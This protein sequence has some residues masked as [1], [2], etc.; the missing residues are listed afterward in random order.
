MK[1]KQ[2]KKIILA[3][4]VLLFLGCSIQR[5]IERAPHGIRLLS[6][7]KIEQAKPQRKAIEDERFLVKK[8]HKTL[9]L[10][11]KA[12]GE[13]D[14][15]IR[16]EAVEVLGKFRSVAERAGHV[17]IAYKVVIPKE[18]LRKSRKLE[19][20]PEVHFDGKSLSCG[21]IEIRGTL[22]DMLQKRQ[23]WQWE[24]WK[25]RFHPTNNR[26]NPERF[27]ALKK[28]PAARIDSL[29][30]GLR[31][32]S[33]YLTERIRLESST[34]KILSTIRCKAQNTNL[35]S[36]S[37]WVPDTLHFS[38][39]SM[40]SFVDNST[41]Y[42]KRIRLK[43]KLREDVR[44]IVFPVGS[45]TI[46]DTLENNQEE[47]SKILYLTDTLLRGINYALDSCTV[48]AY[49]SPEGSIESNMR[50]SQMRAQSVVKRLRERFG[51]DADTIFRARSAGENW[52]EFISHLHKMPCAFSRE[53]IKE[54]SLNENRDLILRRAA[55]RYP[56]QYAKIQQK[57]FPRLR[58]VRFQFFLHDRLLLRDTVITTEV[59][60]LYMRG[61]ELLKKRE[62]KQALEILKD[63]PGINAA[64]AHMSLSHDKTALEI[65]KKEPL[66]AQREYL[67]SILFVRE[68]MWEQAKEAFFI[69]CRLDENMEFRSDMDP[70]MSE[71]KKRIKNEKSD[72]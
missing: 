28:N 56:K 62:Y 17:E 47:L 4:W 53:I 6:S 50:L 22:F 52:E 71:L 57:I 68:H 23:Y 69:S 39:S 27:I 18:V 5:S 65:L 9:Y 19:L 15:G 34:K 12:E 45:Y 1:N 51:E 10:I 2:V 40:L 7:K 20:W 36:Y 66:S 42:I 49:S 44:R 55:I 41:R 70:E 11:P 72:L 48:K 35:S 67:R 58:E 30:E 21:L 8:G 46:V 59:D 33:L 26:I 13:E 32:I 25:K 43:K 54:D 16:I 24:T 63:Y 3:L 31:S 60:S 29:T 14:E 64:I 38:I 61:V 37:F